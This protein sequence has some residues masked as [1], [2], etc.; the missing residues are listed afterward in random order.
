MPD[1]QEAPGILRNCTDKCQRRFQKFYRYGN[2]FWMGRKL[3]WNQEK[4]TSL[5]FPYDPLFLSF[6]SFPFP[7]FLSLSL[8]FPSLPF[9]RGVGGPSLKIWISSLSQVSFSAYWGNLYTYIYLKLFPNFE[10]KHLAV[11]T[12]SAYSEFL[13][14]FPC[15]II[16]VHITGF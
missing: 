4:A 12:N 14:V 11:V 8:P 3:N 16:S 13:N 15:I 10:W 5:S 2:Y 1:R 7:P 9:S 6:P